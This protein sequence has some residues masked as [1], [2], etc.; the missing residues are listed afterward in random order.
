MRLNLR[1]RFSATKH[2][3]TYDVFYK[4]RRVCSV[5]CTGRPRR[6]RLTNLPGSIPNYDVFER[7]GDLLRHLRKL[8]TKN[9]WTPLPAAPFRHLNL[10]DWRRDT[11]LR[12]WGGPV[13]DY[14]TL[15]KR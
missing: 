3:V 12:V 5:V 8:W 13:F 4:G 1:H 2:H 6:W 10:D 7:R 14:G 11:K 9:P 15:R